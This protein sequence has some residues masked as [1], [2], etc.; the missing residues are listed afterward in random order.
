MNLKTKKTVKTPWHIWLIAIF[1]IFIYANG[2]YDYFMMLG[3]NMDYYKAKGYG[4]IVVQYFI[5]YPIPFLILYNIN[6][7][8][9]ILAP[10]L[11]L[12]KKKWATYVALVSAV[13][14]TILLIL[15]FTLRNRWNVLGTSVAIFDIGIVL[16]T[17]VLYFYCRNMN[18]KEVLR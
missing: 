9:G 6:I 13:S 5:N 15:T 4:E 12:F 16:L 18:K 8:C 7:Y 1:F 10:V 11:L 3:H 2:I 14:Y 17:Y